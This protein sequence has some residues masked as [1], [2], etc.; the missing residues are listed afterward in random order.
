[1]SDPQFAIEGIITCVFAVIGLIFMHDVGRL[2]GCYLMH[3]S[4]ADSSIPTLRNFLQ[5]L[6]EL[7]SKKFYGRIGVVLPRLLSG[8]TY[9]TPRQTGRS[10]CCSLSTWGMCGFIA[11]YSFNNQD[12]R[13]LTTTFDIAL[14]LPTIITN[15]GFSA[16]N[17]QLLLV[18]PHTLG[19]PWVPISFHQMNYRNFNDQDHH[20]S[21]DVIR[22]AQIT[23]TIPYGVLIV[24][25]DWIWYVTIVGRNGRCRICG[26]LFCHCRHCRVSTRS[27]VHHSTLNIS[28]PEGAYPF[29]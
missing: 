1:M 29:P 23:G 8:N 22:Q 5:R 11:S 15:I 10:M 20:R 9:A 24:G 7:N 2:H 13:V 21:F 28:R 17:A 18:P 26:N 25:D 16:A 3:S 12:S 6:N 27:N 4:Q 14:F 19:W